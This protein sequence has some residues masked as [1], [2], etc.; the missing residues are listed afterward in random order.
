MNED[1]EKQRTPMTTTEGTEEL[2]NCGGGV[3][4][5]KKLLELEDSSELESSSKRSRLAIAAATAAG[6]GDEDEDEDEEGEEDDDYESKTSAAATADHHGN[7]GNGDHHHHHHRHH[8]HSGSSGG[9]SSSNRNQ[10]FINSDIQNP[11]QFLA[12][13][14]PS[15]NMDKLPAHMSDLEI[16]R[17]I[18]QIMSTASTSETPGGEIIIDPSSLFV[19]QYRHRLEHLNT[20]EQCVDLIARSRHIIVLT[21]A[22]CSVS[23]GIP[24]FRSR[25]GV[26]ARLSVDFPDLPDPQ[27][28][29]DI[30]Y[31][32]H[33][34][35]PFFKF[36][37]EIYP[38]QFQPSISHLFIKKLEETGKLLR[39]YTQNIDTLETV[40]KISNIIQCHGSFA[41]ATCTTCKF[42][43]DSEFI[44]EKIF[45]QE[46]PYCEK[47][48]ANEVFKELTAADDQQQQTASSSKEDSVKSDDDSVA[49][50]AASSS[51][52]GAALS[53]GGGGDSSAADNLSESSS[54]L[55]AM[56]CAP[57]VRHQGKSAGILKPDIV[58]FGEGLPDL[59]H[60]SISE[61]K[62]HCDL[63][64]VIGSSLKVKPVAN[65][66][67]LLDEKVPQ[68][69]I[70]RESLRHM[71]FDV[72]LLG[73]C[74]VIV[75]ELLL[76]LAEKEALGSG[77]T[78]A[79]SN[80]EWSDVCKE[81]RSKLKLM[82][83]EAAHKLILGDEK[84]DDIHSDSEDS[85]SDESILD[86]DDMSSC[87][88]SGEEEEEE[89][90]ED[91][92]GMEES[93]ENGGTEAPASK[94]DEVGK[95]ADQPPEEPVVVND[96]QAADTVA[97]EKEDE[98]ETTT[99][100]KPEPVEKKFL[101]KLF[102]SDN[103]F[104]HIE[105]NV[106]V[107]KGAEVTLKFAN[108]K[109]KH[110]HRALKKQ[111]KKA[112]AAAAAGQ[113]DGQQATAATTEPDQ[114]SST[115]TVAVE[116]TPP[117]VTIATAPVEVE[118]AVVVQEPPVVKK[119]RASCLMDIYNDNLENEEDE[120]DDY[121]EDDGEDESGSGDDSD[122]GSDEESDEDDE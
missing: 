55:F 99:E 70:N 68:I 116:P 79:A 58:F 12:H 100:P 9:A 112:L 111:A 49:R 61:D 11:R 28:M 60:R 4:N 8:H 29:F 85:F 20:I 69:L 104:L 113:E 122:S 46:I 107:F 52:S 62:S 15:F 71:N 90:E 47:C 96:D 119:K 103:A 67:F 98:Q 65:I 7:H 30:A 21:G 63:L 19:Q 2:G 54:S 106:Y 26:Y 18:Y 117:V 32:E 102:D 109:L 37:K 118:E 75:N 77:S 16:T 80:V 6:S 22:G 31:F 88:S 121:D 83:E 95:T 38:G 87:S 59:Y 78:G 66:P 25:D 97:E 89:E 120:D 115:T 24:D 41:T 64:I 73:D 48:K 108:R 40:A 57:M 23:C 35:R 36:A 34:P 45:R 3:K 33:D 27:A 72:E 101:Y 114:T 1:D 81:K 51:S 42:K 110:H 94:D 93:G 84:L 91:E 39:N 76:R 50:F 17:L 92:E 105:P 14:L 43:C 53:G 86:T 10:I 56:T 5:K 13:L 74:D 44:R 82:D